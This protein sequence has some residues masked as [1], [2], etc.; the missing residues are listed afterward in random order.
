MREPI[1]LP[2]WF[3]CDVIEESRRLVTKMIYRSQRNQPREQSTDGDGSK[4]HDALGV[5]G[6]LNYLGE[7]RQESKYTSTV[8]Y[9]HALDA[10][11]M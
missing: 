4:A 8:K 11:C 9:E 3:G 7:E 6:V 5:G 2:L 1:L 10:G